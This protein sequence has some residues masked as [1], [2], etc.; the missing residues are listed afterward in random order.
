MP[1]PHEYAHEHA[2][3][4]RQE[5]HDLLRIPSISTD[6]AYRSEVRRCADWLAAHLRGLGM[7]A[8][9]IPTNRHPLV[10]AEWMGAGADAKTVLTYGH[11]DVQPA[12]VD[13]GWHSDPFEPEER[14]GNI[15]ARGAE[16]NKGQ[17]WLQIKAVESLFHGDQPPACNLKFIIEGEEESG[18]ESIAK[19]VAENPEKLKADVCLISDTGI[20]AFDKPSII[21]ALRGM[22]ATELTVT[23]PDHD[24]HS[25]SF[26]GV[27]H[28]PLQV[29]A[30]IVSKLH[31]ADGSVAVPGFYDDVV[32]MSDA[33]RAELAKTS[34]TEAE[35]ATETGVPQTWGEV[36]FSPRE[37]AGGRPTLEING[38]GG[39]YAGIGFKTVIPSSALVKISCRLVANQD[40]DRI[41]DLLKAYVAQITP[42]TVTVEWKKFGGGHGA[43][44][45]IHAPEMQAAVR[46]YEN[47]WGVKPVF[48]REGGSIPVVAD[49]QRHVGMP[50]LLIGFGLPTDNIHG[51][52]EH[53]NIELF[54]RGVDTIL[55]FYEIYAG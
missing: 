18:G 27:V 19:Y 33:E 36:G 26:G 10:Y 38:I 5:L 50:V 46:A 34:W 12:D 47:V 53:F 7:T 41:Y 28:N 15:Y 29:V 35:V 25:G 22:V 16:D 49:L 42:P 54:H 11:Y 43:L 8:E 6:P 37:R 45:D 21:Y 31:N 14:D 20:L 32:M 13:E 23:G 52:N 1:T 51:P 4:F 55:H 44:V 24:L 17:L 48:L 3:R 30:E 40:P 9:T 39:G 2:E